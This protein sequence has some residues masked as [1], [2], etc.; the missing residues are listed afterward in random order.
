MFTQ[1]QIEA[2]VDLL[3]TLNHDT[4]IYIGTDSVR[5]KNKGRW[6]AKYATVCVI[7]KNGNNGGKLFIARTVESDYDL[8]IGRPSMRLMN[9]VIKSC[10]AYNQ[11]AP[12]VDEFQVELH[13][14]VSTKLEN[15]S[16]C[17]A[18]QAAGYAL[19]VTGLDQEKIKLKPD[20]WS[21]SCSADH[22]ARGKVA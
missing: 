15:G 2:I 7:H 21:A 3:I 6:F 16:S 14:D 1:E 17:V 9:E 8:K 11:L 13:I 18:S 10:E 5:F 22:A 19:G 12:F 20:A 4:R